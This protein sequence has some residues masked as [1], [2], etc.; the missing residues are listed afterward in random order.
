MNKVEAIFR[1][2]MNPEIDSYS[3]F[4]DNA[5]LKSTGLAGYLR[6]KKVTGVYLVGLAGDFCVFSSGMDSLREKFFTFIIEDATRPINREHFSK[7]MQ[8]FR[9][10]GGKILQS[11]DLNK[12]E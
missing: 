8:E 9:A 1:K 12:H 5:H 11:G 2:G 7:V 3:G 6:D 4:Y 10:H